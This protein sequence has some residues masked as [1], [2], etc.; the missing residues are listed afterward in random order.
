MDR[1]QLL[2][3]AATLNVAQAALDEAGLKEAAAHVNAAV[4]VVHREARWDADDLRRMGEIQGWIA[5]QV[6]PGL[7]RSQREESR[8]QGDGPA[9]EQERVPGHSD[10]NSLDELQMLPLVLA[11]HVHGSYRSVSSVTR[12]RTVTGRWSLRSRR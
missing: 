2:G 4:V 6:V 11:A 8:D 10:D 12:T 9:L 3:L 1:E 7:L 5:R